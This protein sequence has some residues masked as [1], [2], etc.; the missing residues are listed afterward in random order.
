MGSKGRGGRMSIKQRKDMTFAKI[1][2]KPPYLTKCGEF[3]V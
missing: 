2:A 3:F 1:L